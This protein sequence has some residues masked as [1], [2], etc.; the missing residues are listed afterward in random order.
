MMKDA[1]RDSEL[2]PESAHGI[3]RH[4]RFGLDQIVDVNGDRESIEEASGEDGCCD[5]VNL[6]DGVGAVALPA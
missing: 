3:E 1:S 5:A 6:S 4:A 2:L